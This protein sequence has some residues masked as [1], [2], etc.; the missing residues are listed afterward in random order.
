M[1]KTTTLT[2]L[3]LAVSASCFAQQVANGGFESW[4]NLGTYDDPTDWITSN[5]NTANITHVLQSNNAYSGSY[6]V[7]INTMTYMNFTIGGILAAP[8]VGNFFHVSNPNVDAVTGWYISNFVQGDQLKVVAAM[9]QGSNT[10]GGS[11][12]F[13]SNSTSVYQQ[14]TFPMTF[15]QQGVTDSAALAFSEVTASDG[16]TGLSPNTY[17]ILDDVDFVVMSA[18]RDIHKSTGITKLYPNP[19][20]ATSWV[21]YCIADKSNVVLSVYDLNGKLVQTLVN[22][23]QTP[24]NYRV[25]VNTFTM[26]HGFYLIQL[27]AG[28]YSSTMKLGVSE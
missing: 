28:D 18:V 5:N 2:L 11:T 17:V 24:G 4:T 9:R 26:K 27:N 21:E 25:A 16:A 22:E 13:I 1:K 14:F 6:A 12:D 20:N 23:E 10:V 3:L 15:T 19:G 8:S 7:R